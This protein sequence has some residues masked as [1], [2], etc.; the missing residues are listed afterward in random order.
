MVQ[1]HTI[2]HIPYLSQDKIRHHGLKGDVVVFLVIELEAGRRD[3][4]I[5]RRQRRQGIVVQAGNGNE[6]NVRSFRAWASSLTAGDSPEK[7]TIMNK[8]SLVMVR[9]RL[10]NSSRAGTS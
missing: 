2:F 9:M 1:I 4:K 6:G 5:D 10:R 8:S 3:V 7:E